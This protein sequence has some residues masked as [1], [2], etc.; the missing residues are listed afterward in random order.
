[1][2]VPTN[3]TAARWGNHRTAKS[4]W[5]SNTRSLTQAFSGSQA[6]RAAPDTVELRIMLSDQSHSHLI[7]YCRWRA[8]TPR[9]PFRYS[10]LQAPN[11]AACRR[12]QLPSPRACGQ[13]RARARRSHRH[14][15]L[16]SSKAEHSNAPP[17]RKL[18]AIVKS[19]SPARVCACTRWCAHRDQHEVENLRVVLELQ[20]HGG[21]A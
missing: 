18:F 5:A 6:R 16:R 12:R 14:R 17:T 1:M 10:C 19:I 13:S 3:N 2:T 15:A 20:D 4:G 21:A 8:T 7:D 11:P 9:N